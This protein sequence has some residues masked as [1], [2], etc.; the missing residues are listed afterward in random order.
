[1][2]EEQERKKNS[3]SETSKFQVKVDGGSGWGY[4]S[5]DGRQLIDFHLLKVEDELDG[6][7]RKK[8]N[9]C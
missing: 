9:Q 6:E 4:G 8:R 5:E 2:Q 7:Y 1:M 3:G